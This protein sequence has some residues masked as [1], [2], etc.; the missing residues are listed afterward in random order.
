MTVLLNRI[1]NDSI[2]LKHHESRCCAPRKIANWVTVAALRVA[3]VE[4]DAQISQ[5]EHVPICHASVQSL[6]IQHCNSTVR[7]V[8]Y[9]LYY[10][11]Q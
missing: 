11:H 3:I 7:F 5:S 9:Y 4:R 8:A 6:V 10:S 2:R 1:D